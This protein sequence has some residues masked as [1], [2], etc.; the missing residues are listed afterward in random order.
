MKINYSASGDD[1]L[2]GENFNMHLA[3]AIIDKMLSGAADDEKLNDNEE[4]LNK[5]LNNISEI[6]TYLNAFVDSKRVP[7]YRRRSYGKEF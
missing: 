2:R 5:A 4:L 7:C 3:S 1:S 6:A